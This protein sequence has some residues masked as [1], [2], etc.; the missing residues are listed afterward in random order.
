MLNSPMFQVCLEGL[1]FYGHHGVQPEERAVGHW[2]SADLRLTVDG[3]ADTTDRIEDTVDYGDAATVVLGV[4]EERRFATLEALC[5][6]VADRLLERFPHAV[7]AQVK[8][9]KL[10]P[11]IPHT[12]RL[13][14]VE[15]VAKRGASVVCS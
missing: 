1:E 3:A 10:V 8:I 7:E 9:G 4:S 2:Y 11:P 5:R 13:A 12:A 14:A 15:L 6:A